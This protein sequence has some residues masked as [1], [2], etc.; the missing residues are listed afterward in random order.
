MNKTKRTRTRAQ[1]Q[2]QRLRQQR[3]GDAIRAARK[4]AGLTQAELGKAIGGVPQK[5]LSRWENGLAGV[6]FDIIFDIEHA[7]GLEAGTLLAEAGYV[8]R[9]PKTRN[10]RRQLQTDPA[11]DPVLRPGLIGHYDT[12]IEAT[13][14]MNNSHP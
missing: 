14:K 10:V 5:A 4:H 1:L 13:A 9:P 12:A 3:L 11:V 7:L 8:A 6:D 2:Q